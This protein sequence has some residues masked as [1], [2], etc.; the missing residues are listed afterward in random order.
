MLVLI[1]QRLPIVKQRLPD[2]PSCRRYNSRY[3]RSATS[4]EAAMPEL[5]FRS[6]AA[7]STLL[8]ILTCACL[9]VLV[10]A[11]AAG[12]QDRSSQPAPAYLR[13]V[14][15]DVLLDRS[16][17]MVAADPGMP[18]VTGDRLRTRRGRV[19]VLF[20]DAAAVDLDENSELE[21]PGAQGMRLSSGRAWLSVPRESTTVSQVDTPAAT[22][23]NDSPGEYRISVLGI[24]TLQT[25]LA[26]T[27]GR[28]QLVG[29]RG[30][31]R[32][33][34]GERSLASLNDVPSHPETLTADRFDAFDQWAAARRD[35]R[36]AGPSAQY[37][38]PDLR[39]Y[40][41]TLDQNG[42]WQYE[43]N[44]GYV[45]YPAVPTT[46]RPYYSG[47]WATVPIYG[48]TWIGAEHWAW[49]TH[50]YGRWGHA[51][52]KW[53]WIPERHWSPGW[54]SWGAAPD[55]ISW[56]PLGYDNRPV[57]GIS[58]WYG[59]GGGWVVTP[60]DRFGV[61]REYVSHYAVSPRALS[62]QTPFVTDTGP[63]AAPGRAVARRII[64]SQTPGT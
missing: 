61:G 13:I 30:S 15:G 28:G 31:V 4:P 20:P 54:V 11:G 63:P 47:Y 33:E 12:A 21:F 49:P 35:E 7:T 51:H 60:R 42:T 19:E 57:Y 62:P 53:F 29:D 24:R 38:P 45:W 18:L 23:Y 50:H 46:W 17:D 44:Y 34:A 43:S 3:Q 2:K 37:L 16:G 64:G 59:T 1:S 10:L 58:A 14:E 27:R 36:T 26:V 55:Y 41:T 22:A 25:E 9:L 40:G 56:C 32:L 39:A 8:G 52:S 5:P 48:W 6:R